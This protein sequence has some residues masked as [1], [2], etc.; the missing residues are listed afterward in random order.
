MTPMPLHRSHPITILGNLWRVLYL[1]IIPVLR[2]FFPDELKKADAESFFRAAN[3]AKPSLIRVDA[4]EVSYSLHIIL[5][6]ELERDLFS[7]AADPADLPDLWRSKMKDV[8]GIEP[9]T[10]AQGVLQDIH[11]SMGSFGYFPSYAL[12]NLYGLQFFGKLRSDIPD[13]EN[14][15]C[16]GNFA[17]IHNWLR[18]NIHKWGRRLDPSV[19]LEKVTGDELSVEPFLG[20]IEKKYSEIYGI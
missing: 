1:V 16:N 3:C 13:Y 17:P 12:G 20:Y 2:G 9:E 10:D 14:L 6:F 5:R 15:I 19:L 8:I 11:W 4:D 18:E 7:G